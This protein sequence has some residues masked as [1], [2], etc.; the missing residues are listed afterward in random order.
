MHALQYDRFGI[1]GFMFLLRE[2]MA[3]E[4]SVLTGLLLQCLNLESNGF[5][6][7]SKFLANIY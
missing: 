5:L 4:G 2:H 6:E 3:K 7:A 1:V